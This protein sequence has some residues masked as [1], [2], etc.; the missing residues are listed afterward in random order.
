MGLGRGRCWASLTL[1]YLKEGYLQTS[2]ESLYP[3]LCPLPVRNLPQNGLKESLSLGEGG[4]GGRDVQPG[5]DHEKVSQ[6]PTWTV[7]AIS[8]LVVWLIDNWPPRKSICFLLIFIPAGDISTVPFPTPFPRPSE[9]RRS[10]VLGL[11][12]L[13]SPNLKDPPARRK[14]GTGHLGLQN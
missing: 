11:G 12:N 10:A 6:G 5:G 2:L 13:T 14:T 4:S 7:F 3:G 9:P 1:G 8:G